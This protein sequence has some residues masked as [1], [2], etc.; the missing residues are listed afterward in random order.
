MPYIGFNGHSRTFERIPNQCTICHCFVNPRTV[1]EPIPKGYSSRE[2]FVVFQCPSCDHLFISAYEA[3]TS[4]KYGHDDYKFKDSFP[5]VHKSRD[6]N[7]SIQ[8]LSPRFS[9]IYNQS[10]K[11]ESDRLLE[12]CGP[13][14]RKALEI[15]VKDYLIN[16]TSDDEEMIKRRPLGQCIQQISDP[17]IQA[18]A[19]RAVWL[20][21]DETHY[22]RRWENK[23]LQDLKKLIDLV[24]HYI[25]M[26]IIAEEY[27]SEMERN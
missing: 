3:R 23:D 15:L 24:V 19:E 14:Y 9:N 4:T 25:E 16:K 8:A 21:N 5:I 2:C 17:R 26:E 1:G 6:F 12:I 13:G 11:A 20:G 7:L 22:V 27:Q 18:C 10:L